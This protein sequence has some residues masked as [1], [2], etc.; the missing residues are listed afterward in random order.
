MSEGVRSDIT[1]EGILKGDR[2]TD[3][4]L[5]KDWTRLKRANIVKT[6]THADSGGIICLRKRK[7][8]ETENKEAIQP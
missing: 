5:K 8:P 1:N 6:G 2:P 4:D 3:M 7:L